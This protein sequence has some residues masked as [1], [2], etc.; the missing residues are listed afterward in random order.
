MGHISFVG[1][2]DG[3]TLSGGA[4]A[5]APGFTLDLMANH[6][7]DF[8]LTS[9][10]L[11][12]P[13]NRVTL[14]RDGNIVLCYK[15]NNEE[16]HKRLDREAEGSDATAD[17]VRGARPRLPPGPVRAQSVRGPAHSAGRRG[18][19]ERDHPFRQRSEDLRARPN[20]KAHE[21]DNLYVVDGS[22]F[23]SSGAVNPA[24]T[25]MANAL[26]VGDHLIERLS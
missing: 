2:L 26:R 8:W 9:E 24:L 1:K 25:I 7:L 11:P 14:D 18:A 22:F 10:D 16:G 12:D 4:P 23:P 5:I 3:I 13:D 15:P 6:S 20:C 17:A 21:V 19:P